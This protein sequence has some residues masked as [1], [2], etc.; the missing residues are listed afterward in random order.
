M[1]RGGERERKEAGSGG[2]GMNGAARAL[3]DSKERVL[4]LGESFEKQPRCAFHT[5]RCE[6][7]RML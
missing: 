3:F 4:L 5:L 1:E 6:S 2:L 7:K